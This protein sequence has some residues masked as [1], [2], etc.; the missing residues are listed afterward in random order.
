MSNDSSNWLQ[1]APPPTSLLRID[2]LLVRWNETARP[3]DLQTFLD[4]LV[5]WGAG[6]RDYVSAAAAFLEQGSF[7]EAARC[8]T[9]LSSAQV[10]GSDVAS[11]LLRLWSE[12]RRQVEENIGRVAKDRQRLAGQPCNPEIMAEIDKALADL[13]AKLQRLPDRLE[14]LTRP[15]LVRLAGIDPA[16]LTAVQEQ[17]EYLTLCL[18]E[19]ERSTREREREL[20]QRLSVIRHRSAQAI[21]K[22][23]S[24]A[25]LD[26]KIESRA[27]S[28][29]GEIRKHL[30]Q[31]A[32]GPAESALE[33]L[34]QLAQGG[35]VEPRPT[36]TSASP[37]PAQAPPVRLSTIAQ[38]A[39]DA[40]STQAVPES[41]PKELRDPPGWDWNPERLA[42][43][44]AQ[45]LAFVK[46]GQEQTQ[47]ADAEVARGAYLA[48]S[49]KQRLMAGESHDALV[50]FRDAYTW[51]TRPVR[52]LPEPERW[53]RDCAW[54]LLLCTALAFSPKEDRA[55]VIFPRNLDALF[56]SDLGR[57][58]LGVMDDR[59]LFP[60]LA[61][62]LLSMTTEA[63][64]LILREHLW[65]YL[66]SHPVA[67]QDLVRGFAS[68]FPE[69]PDRVLAVIA[70]LMSGLGEGT[71][72]VG[73]EALRDLSQ[74]G[75]TAGRDRRQTRRLCDEALRV[76]HPQ[77]EESG[78][79][80][81]ARDGL[82]SRVPAL[83]DSPVPRV[84]VQ[85]VAGKQ[86]LS[87]R[88][89][90]VLR[91]HYLRGADI[92]RRVR[93][94]PGV[95]KQDNLA[96]GLFER[97]AAIGRL[98][99]DNTA[100]VVVRYTR[101]P[102]L[103]GSVTLLITVNQ[104]DA[105]EGVTLP[106]EVHGERARFAVAPPT[107]LK[108][109]P[110]NPYVVGGAITDIDRI[111]GRQEKVEEIVR[112]L[113]GERQDNI[114]LVLGERRIGKTTVLNHLREHPA[115]KD[116]YVCVFSDLQSAGDFRN[117]GAFYRAYLIDPILCGLRDKGLREIQ[118]PSAAALSAAPH[119][120]FE[121]FMATVDKAVGGAGKRLLV[122]L[123][124]L[125]KV[126]VAE[127]RRREQSDV[128]LPDDVIAAIRAVL[129]ASRSVS[130][131]LAG[132]TDVVRRHI[133]GP[134][135]RLFSLALL[136]ELGR[137]GPNAAKRLIADLADPH[138]E[139][140]TLAQK[141]I[142]AETG[143]HP[144]LLQLVCFELFEQIVQ[145]G[146][147]VATEADVV[148]VIEQKIIPKAQPFSY[149]VETIRDRNDLAV[150]DALAALQT[151]TAFVCIKD[152]HRHLRRKG[153]EWPEEELVGRL[154]SMCRQAPSLIARRTNRRF[155]Y[156]IETPL[157]ARHRKRLQQSPTSL[158]VRTQSPAA[159]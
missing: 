64:D 62:I 23:L 82:E 92:L 157:V 99:P 100:E 81:A 54:G 37:T 25:A 121:A 150:L 67:L 72:S 71:D 86:G 89:R 4:D 96:V 97:P 127:E 68:D 106:V 137:L 61:H 38:L 59:E 19:A 42:G 80:E 66:G 104:W 40:P 118:A 9:H 36:P 153:V 20:N 53:R 77:S 120:A 2:P 143:G 146:E 141:R 60:D 108:D 63:M 134:D 124:E 1:A 13:E 129:L 103:G 93:V 147:L 24:M 73:A 122:L 26:V 31:Q 78:L 75:A 11:R 154:E 115:I 119:K 125:E 91:L 94:Q 29:Q 50:F 10:E 47:T 44:A 148:H 17:R 22:V 45:A 79:A 33:E 105:T 83:A 69:L 34:E 116:R 27:W 132:V 58:A 48:I 3:E 84:A 65:D 117:I 113:I 28:L 140:T 41:F 155:Q 14:E 138:Y 49:A 158:V 51:A 136:V 152:I 133:E 98:K 5:A 131:V 16:A 30:D 6:I 112:R 126:L 107:P 76:L 32:I 46:V 142:V 130:F 18:E 21:G 74:R 159:E 109:K 145:E 123:D 15:D 102:D 88:K 156:R 52:D 128:E 57:L 110:V 43:L 90:V 114:V 7:S 101:L 111:F 55:A 135:N 87:S 139:V 70:T 56:Q 12:W 95:E 144:Y 39:L 151:G 8:L 35:V 85:L 149:I